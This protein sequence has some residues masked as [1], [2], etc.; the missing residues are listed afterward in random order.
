MARLVLLLAVVVV[1]VPGLVKASHIVGRRDQ[2]DLLQQDKLAAGL[3]NEMGIAQQ[4]LG[5]AEEIRNTPRVDPSL[6]LLAIDT[7]GSFT[8]SSSVYERLEKDIAAARP[9]LNSEDQWL[10]DYTMNWNYAR[11][12]N[13]F[14]K[15][16]RFKNAG[17]TLVFYPDDFETYLQIYSGENEAW[18]DLNDWYGAEHIRGDWR[19]GRVIVRFKDCYNKKKLAD[20]YSKLPG[21]GVSCGA[22]C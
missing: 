18:N 7:T 8:A 9:I 21:V 16:N 14:T 17:K 13:R 11:T 22:F 4:K 3:E 12:E 20:I 1:V 2:I 10:C 6:E 15:H 5:T 19:N